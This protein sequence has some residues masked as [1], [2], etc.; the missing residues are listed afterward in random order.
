[1]QRSVIRT[2]QVALPA[3]RQSFPTPGCVFMLRLRPSH[4]TVVA[5]SWHQHRLLMLV[6]KVHGREIEIREA[7]SVPLAANSTPEQI[8][9]R[10]AEELHERHVRHF[11]LLVGLPRS[12]VEMLS[13]TLPPATDA[14]L[15]ELVQ[16]EVLRQL[17]DLPEEAI[18]DFYPGQ[19]DTESLRRVEA[20]VLRPE[21][22][23]QI[24]LA[25]ESA[26]RPA[27][28]LVLRPLAIASLFSR[29][30]GQAHAKALLLTVMDCDAD[31]SLFSHGQVVF[32]RTVR[33]SDDEG[34]P[35][36]AS[37]VS[38][39][40]RRTLA[41]APLEPEDDDDVGHVYIF[42]DLRRS[43]EFIEQ[44]AED[45]QLPVSLLDP[46]VGLRV[47]KDGRSAADPPLS[48]TDRHG[49]RLRRRL[50]ACGFCA[51][52]AAA[53]ATALRPKDRFLRRRRSDRFADGYHAFEVT[54]ECRR[55]PGP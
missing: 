8:G 47:S 9:Q 18:V 24:K 16:N 3:Q 10:L 49:A 37:R 39:E 32:S 44:L 19:G 20:V 48:C 7:V 55:R 42:D 21:M 29:L 34:A 52:Q 23:A 15:A 50:S 30:A 27:T 14:E 38:D 31:M 5:F 33:L 51:S 2:T 25:C 12:R 54:A 22:L 40:I 41:V 11:E 43:N 26:G 1:M 6:A 4:S 28:Q 36:D 45:L 13:L 35:L 46:L 53:A 17:T